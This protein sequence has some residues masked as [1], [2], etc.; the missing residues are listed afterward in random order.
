MLAKDADETRCLGVL[1]GLCPQEAQ[2]STK[3]PGTVISTA[4][5]RSSKLSFPIQVVS[6]VTAPRARHM[7][8]PPGL[9]PL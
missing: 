8:L 7:E 9:L 3:T 5:L 6:S 1:G 4:H 2:V